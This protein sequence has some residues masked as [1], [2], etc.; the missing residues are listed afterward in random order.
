M[1]R[2]FVVMALIAITTLGAC[3]V[4]SAQGVSFITPQDGDTVRDMVRLQATKPSPDEGWISYKIESGGRGDFVGAVISPFTYVW[5]TRARGEDGKDLYA[6]G[7]YTITAVAM[8]PSGRKVGEASITVTL[9][10][11]LSASE[12]P[13]QVPLMLWYERNQQ[14]LYR[15]EARW[16]IRPATD[17]EEP[18]DVYTIARNYDGALISNWK[19]LVMS[20]SVAAGHAVLHVVVG[21][22]GAQAGTSEVEALARAGKV[23]TYRAL[24]DGEMRLKHSDDTPFELAEISVPLGRQMVSVGDSWRGRITIWPDPLKGTV[25]TGGM[26]G[27]MG[28]MGAPGMDMM[29]APGMDMGAMPGAMPGM[30]MEPGMEGGME[31][32]MGATAETRPPTSIE[33]RTVPATHTVEGFEW[34]MGQPTVRIR[35]TFSVDDDKITIPTGGGGALG[36]EVFGGIAG[37]PGMMGGPPPDAGMMGMMPGGFGDTGAAMDGGMMGGAGGVEH[38]TSYTGE[39]ITYWAY[40]LNRP[41]RIVDTIVHTLEI[42]RAQQMGEMG[43]GAEMGMMGMPMEPGMMM[44]P[45]MMPPEPGVYGPGGMPPGMAPGMEPGMMMGPGEFGMG[46]GMGQMEPAEPMKV[47]VTISLVIQETDL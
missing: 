47:R 10:N 8:S 4:A 14:A 27:E 43:M 41:I 31:G 45:E 44:G 34:V 28:M 21:S 22:S 3:L 26:G 6:D 1:R 9:K 33:T 37:E 17:E 2:R 38:D 15:A 24:R 39:R 5:D 29:A 23:H 25:S 40:E 16:S 46:M 13:R 36:G 11:S 42:E 7:Q 32:G 12:A 18:E 20:P 19:N 30:G 35:S